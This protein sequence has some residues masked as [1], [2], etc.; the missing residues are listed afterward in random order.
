MKDWD[1]YNKPKSECFSFSEVKR[2]IKRH[3]NATPM[4]AQERH[5]A[6]ADMEASARRIVDEKNRPYDEEKAAL[7]AEFW[8]D[9]RE[10]I[11]Y[12][13]MLNE[14]QIGILESKAWQDGHSAGYSEVF[15]HLQD[16]GDFIQD[17]N[18]AND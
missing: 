17:I 10:E 11:G 16:L 7:D 15:I 3:I 5:D 18:D 13:K 1:Y 6:F 8:R 9:A 4:T 2:E 14:K 12:G